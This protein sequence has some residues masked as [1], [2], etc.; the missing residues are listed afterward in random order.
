MM[1]SLCRAENGIQITRII[2]KKLSL[3]FISKLILAL[4]QNLS[5]ATCCMGFPGSSALKKLPAVAG[6]SA[7]VRGSGRSPGE[8]NIYRLQYSCLGNFMD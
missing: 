5:L 7:L 3:S 2:V 4:L 6:D 8:G 1:R